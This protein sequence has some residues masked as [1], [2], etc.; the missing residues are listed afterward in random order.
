MTA[1]LGDVELADPPTGPVV[2]K[3]CAAGFN[4]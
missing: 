2:Q 1:V 4:V 3:R